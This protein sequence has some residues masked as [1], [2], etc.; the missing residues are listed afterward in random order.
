MGDVATIVI[1]V[2]FGD[3]L[4]SSVEKARRGGLHISLKT[5]VDDLVGIYRTTLGKTPAFTSPLRELDKNVKIT[6]KGQVLK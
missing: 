2:R 3:G 6:V 4:V 5:V 1:E